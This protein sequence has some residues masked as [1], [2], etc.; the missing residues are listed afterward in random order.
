MNH[1]KDY[2]ILTRYLIRF[3]NFQSRSPVLCED[4]VINT[5]NL[6]DEDVLPLLEEVSLH[7]G[8]QFV[9]AIMSPT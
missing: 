2:L 1:L 5:G 9:V 4:L 6:A 3:A 7:F 8:L